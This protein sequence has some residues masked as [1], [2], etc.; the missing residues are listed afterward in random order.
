MAKNGSGKTVL[1]HLLLIFLTAFTLLSCG[2]GGGG[3]DEGDTGF[4]SL[5]TAI[6]LEA[7]PNAIVANPGTSCE[8]RATM[9]T[10]SGTP[11]PSGT[12]VTFSTTLGTFGSGT[13]Q[14]QGKTTDDS[15]VATVSLIA[16]SVS[17]TALVTARSN[18]V[19]QQVSVTFTATTPIPASLTLS[20]SKTTVL[21][22]RS[23]STTVT[24]TVKD[25]YNAVIPGATVTFSAS[26][27]QLSASSVST[28]TGVKAETGQASVV[29]SAGD[30]R[31]NQL[32]TVTAKTGTLT[33]AVHIQTKGTEVTL[34]QAT[35]TLK[36]GGD[37]VALTVSVKDADTSPIISQPVSFTASPAGRVILSADSGNTD[38]N[39]TL[40]I[41][42]IPLSTGT[43]TVTA[44]SMGARASREFRVSNPSQDFGILSPTD[45]PT[46][47]LTDTN[48]VVLVNAPAQANVQFATTFGTFTGSTASGQVVTE[49][50]SGGR[51]SA[52]FRATEAGVAT[53]LVSDAS[54]A[55]ISDSILV[56]VS[57]AAATAARISL[58][59]NSR[60]IQPSTGGVTNS[61]LLKTTVW[62]ISGQVIPNVPVLLTL[63]NTTGGGEYVSPVIA[64]TDSTG[65]ATATFT[66]GS[67]SSGNAGVKVTA[68]VLGMPSVAA[69]EVDIIIGGTAGSVIISR[70][71]KIETVTEAGKDTYYKLPMAVLV[72]D[73]SGKGLAGVTVTLSTWP[74]R[75][76]AGYWYEYEENK[77]MPVQTCILYNED[78]NRNGQKDAGEDANGD[79][80]LTPPSTASGS[81][82]GTVYTGDDGTAVFDLTYVKTSAAWIEAEITASVVVYGTETRSTYTF[83]LPYLEDE[84]CELPNS[85]YRTKEIT[86]TAS[87]DLLTADGESRS[88]LTA[89]VTNA[90]GDPVEDGQVVLFSIASGR[91]SVFPASATTRG[92]VA[93]TTYT[94]SRSIGTETV[95]ATVPDSACTYATADIYL[96]AISRPTADFTY[97]EVGDNERL[98]FNDASATPE[99][100]VIVSWYWTFTGCSPA[101][102]T[103][104][105]PGIVRFLAGPGKYVITLTVT[106][107]LGYS[108]T[109]MKLVALPYSNTLPTADFT[110]EDLGDG[111]RVVF[112]DASS[113]GAGTWIV[114]W[115]WTFESGSP[116]SSS[117]RF[118]GMVSFGAPGTYMVTLTVTNNLG[119]SHTVGKA[120]K[121]SRDEIV[122][123]TVNADFEAADLGDGDRVHFMDKSYIDEPHVLIS[124][125]WTFESGTPS[126][127]TLQHPGTVHFGTPGIYLVTLTVTADTGL[128]RSVAK[129]IMVTTSSPLPDTK[130]EADFE[131]TDLNDRE[132]ILY[133]DLSKPAS[134]T[135]IASWSWTFSGGDPSTSTARHPGSISYPTG[136]GW[137]VTRLL[138]TN[139][140]GETDE[141]VK[142]VEV[143]S[144]EESDPTADFIWV[145]TGTREI[146]F[147]NL[148]T[149]AAGTTIVEQVWNFGDGTISTH[150]GAV[151]NLVHTYATVGEYLVTLTVK[152]S[153]LPDP[154]THTRGK[155]IVVP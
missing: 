119:E 35:T 66:A 1:L 97:E 28:A 43:V 87:P 112:N 17:G 70:G 116:S 111:N 59:T 126:T 143:R 113:A 26:G 127:S 64:Y 4:S 72:T 49:P 22:S 99:G 92:G 21:T 80:V 105:D 115:Y 114:S 90:N 46:G 14:I 48:L 107:D 75:W 109:A 8:I 129:S 73:A 30:D 6:T 5:T 131:G 96:T 67:V 54:D 144:D 33:S 51:A 98:F 100:T 9:T 12:Y 85:P 47:V 20:L 106:N 42:L 74:N 141:A 76:A 40:Q 128:V 137:Y 34:S 91:G 121:T 71:S 136:P 52:T 11:V 135:T 117:L 58:Q 3:G 10:S 154:G 149:A 2:G 110:Y 39:G 15:G 37:P 68:S 7:I 13:T 60:V 53:I 122:Y 36:I 124:W 55:S 145:S 82:P 86:L 104:Q 120:V 65:I 24:A 18:N 130:P 61:A 29:F 88:T 84:Q 155:I 79:G 138:V 118:P 108:D 50:V 146:T 56:V 78:T 31:A 134:G 140:F 101:T 103:S 147:T 151:I 23:D 44:E 27:G 81:V 150:P 123:Y 95:A 45:N 32:V 93:T 132:H 62:N 69:S 139:N 148:S 83:W 63:S 19:S 152:N 94:A 89:V 153:V 41:Q 133:T 125:Y 142:A 25:Q 102:S 77:C 16:G 38:M 57:A